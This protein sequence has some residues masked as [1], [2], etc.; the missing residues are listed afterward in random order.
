VIRGSNPI[1]IVVADD[2]TMLRR[3]VEIA[4]EERETLE[5]VG[6]AADGPEAV[7]AV[8]KHHPDVLVLDLALPHF[9]GFEVA[10]RLREATTSTRIL[11]LTARDDAKAVFDSM[12]A[13]VHGFLDKTSDMD[14]IADAI[15]KIASGG[16]VF[17]A[18]QEQGALDHLG[19]FL[20]STR[21]SSRVTGTLTERETQV[22]SLIGEGL[23]TR[24]MASRLQVSQRTVES[25][26]E[27]LYR[28]LGVNSRVQA[29]A[30]AAELGV[31]ERRQS[32]RQ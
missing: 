6:E 17:T 7:E 24:Q 28:K 10:R 3:I 29:V 2:H 26:I 30:R 19:T 21:E 12:R 18:Q 9:D 13:E 11:I 14:E 25:H 31:I 23:T 16:R 27:K 32:P 22:L 4:C 20:R 8:L 1:R 15:E 5:L